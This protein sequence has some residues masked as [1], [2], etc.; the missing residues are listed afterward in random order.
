M[1][2]GYIEKGYTPDA[3]DLEKIRQFTRAEFSAD[4]LYT[5]TVNL[6]NNDVDRDF[7][8]FSVSALEEL[9]VLF[10]GKTG[11]KDHSMKSDNQLARIYEASVEKIDG[12]KTADGEDY[13]VLRAKAYMVR[14]QE[15]R[16]FITEIE[17]GIKK[18]VSVSCSM[19]ETICSVC[20]KNKKLERCVH[21]QGSEYGGKLCVGILNGAL[22]AYEWSFVAVPAQREA[23]VTKTFEFKKGGIDVNDITKCLG[24]GDGEVV[25]SRSDANALYSYFEELEQEAELGREYKKNLK[26]EI[27]SLCAKSL[28][29]LDLQTFEKVASIM[30][31]KEL[32]TFKDAFEKQQAAENMPHPQLSRVKKENKKAYKEFKI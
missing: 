10:I 11:I 15:N 8:R 16:S 21:K 30:T 6:C 3:G 25:L 31:A 29:Q 27:V 23:G 28:P 2:E 12:R 4:E 24:A 18:E 32:I 1:K 26:K 5:F 13:Y 22:D 20:G 14:T 19:N 17:A 9:A 7:E